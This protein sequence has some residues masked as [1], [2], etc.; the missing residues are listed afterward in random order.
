[1]KLAYAYFGL[2][3]LLFPEVAHAHG[4]ETL[5][6]FPGILLIQI[7]IALFIYRSNIYR[8]NRWGYLFIYMLF[9]TGSWFLSLNVPGNSIIAYVVPIALPAMPL[10]IPIFYRKNTLRFNKRLRNKNA[11]FFIILLIQIS[12]ILLASLMPYN[13]L[14]NFLGI[15]FLYIP[16]TISNLVYQLNSDAGGLSLSIIIIGMVSQVLL[17]SYGLCKL[18]AWTKNIY[19]N[20]NKGRQ[21]GD[22]DR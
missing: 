20:G 16:N 13:E 18:I 6:Y 10:L 22:G 21:A 9:L 14:A 19:K 2:L 3:V 7:T 4:E 11:C 12:I 1:M 15:I 8:Q 17:I 5:F